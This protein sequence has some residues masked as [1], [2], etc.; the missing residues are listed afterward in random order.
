MGVKRYKNASINIKLELNNII[1]IQIQSIIFV[2]FSRIFWTLVLID[3][4]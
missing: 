3:K 4:I 1:S 2:I